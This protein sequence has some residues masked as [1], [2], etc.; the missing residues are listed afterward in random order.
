MIEALEVLDRDQP[1]RAAEIWD[2]ARAVFP[3]E[4]VKSDLALKLL[5]RLQR[6]DDIEALMKAGHDRYPNDARFAEGAAQVAYERGN[7]DEAFQRATVLYRKYPRSTVGYR[8]AAASL[9]LM[10]RFTEAETVIAKGLNALPHDVGMR[11][12]YAKLAER[13]KDWLAA[14]ERWTYVDEVHGH[15]AG[16]AGAASALTMLGRYEEAESLLSSRLHKFSAE[17]LIWLQFARISE[18]KGDW[19]EAASRWA[20]VRKRFPQRAVGYVSSLPVLARVADREQIEAV[21]LEGIDRIPDDPVCLK[22][23]ALLAHR[24]GDFALADQRWSTLRACFP[25]CREGYE[26]GA[27][28]LAALGRTSESTRLLAQLHGQCR[29]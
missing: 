5:F 29:A 27:A 1:K 14:L 2:H 9:S 23:Y 19:E 7:L 28:A 8:T 17:M 21:L 13:R 15:V 20:V 6:Y 24:A 10:N 18:G 3:D 26:L 4:A 12:E 25:A 16:A 11:I 22:E